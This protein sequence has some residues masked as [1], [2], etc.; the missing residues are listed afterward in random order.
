MLRVRAVARRVRATLL[1]ATPA[2]DGCTPHPGAE[3]DLASGDAAG[4]AP[5][6]SAEM[7]ASDVVLLVRQL[8]RCA[9]LVVHP[10]PRERVFSAK[11]LYLCT[12]VCYAPQEGLRTSKMWVRVA[13]THTIFHA[14]EA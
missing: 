11:V 5:G 12:Q 8:K 13:L 14:W 4:Y 3:P 10:E 9:L 6:A 2:G 7:E 1:P